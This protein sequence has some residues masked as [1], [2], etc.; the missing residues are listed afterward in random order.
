MYLIRGEKKNLLNLLIIVQLF[1]LYCFAYNP[2]P[3]FIVLKW[4]I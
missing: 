2:L 1:P 4:S 3:D